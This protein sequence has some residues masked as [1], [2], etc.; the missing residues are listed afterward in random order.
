MGFGVTVNE[1][2]EIEWVGIGNFRSGG[3]YDV[4]TPEKL[5]AF[6]EKVKTQHPDDYTK[7]MEHVTL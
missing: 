5:A 7:L 6:L 3:N 4:S 2:G 1:Q